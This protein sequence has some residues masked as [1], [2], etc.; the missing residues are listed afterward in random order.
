MRRLLDVDRNFGRMRKRSAIFPA[1]SRFV[2][3]RRRRAFSIIELIVAVI[4]IGILTAILTPTLT[5][6]MAETRLRA[7]ELE[8]EDLVNAMERVSIDTGYFF[9]LYVLDDVQGG[10]N[11]A[12]TDPASVIDG[13]DDEDAT[14]GV[15]PHTEPSKIFIDPV[16]QDFLVNF[17]DKFDKFQEDEIVFGWAGP[18]L[19]WKRDANSNDWPDDP[20]G[21][22]YLL[23]TKVGGL[24][25]KHFDLP[26]TTIAQPILG[27]DEIFDDDGPQFTP[28]GSTSLFRAPADDIFDRPTVLSLGPNGL[29][30][31][32]SGVT[33]DIEDT[34]NYGKGD[35][36]F[37]HFGGAN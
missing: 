9:R 22:D 1:P 21:N 33:N 27:D 7:A 5:K 24:F 31:D 18:Y 3:A 28:N 19:N 12:N 10:D 13:T 30:G 34:G 20:W 26:N 15:N 25:P 6:R 23:F 11:I 16:S 29:P 8:L 17:E 4:I 14:L 32:G 36:I 37:R 35:D 2:R